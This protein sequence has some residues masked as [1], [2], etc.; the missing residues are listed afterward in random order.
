MKNYKKNNINLLLE[1]ADI[2]R[3]QCKDN[4][5]DLMKCIERFGCGICDDYCKLRERSEKCNHHWAK[6]IQNNFWAVS[7]VSISVAMIII[8]ETKKK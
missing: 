3:C 6:F 2:D 1:D 8:S 4:D 5:Y 7:F